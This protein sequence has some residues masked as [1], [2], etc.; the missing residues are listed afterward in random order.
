MDLNKGEKS[1]MGS[2]I[3]VV[4]STYLWSFVESYFVDWHNCSCNMN[5]NTMD[6][7]GHLMHLN[8]EW[9]N[10]IEYNWRRKQLTNHKFD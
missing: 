10:T 1:M 6:C 4:Q 8:N 9:V 2:N 7:N 5:Y 3:I